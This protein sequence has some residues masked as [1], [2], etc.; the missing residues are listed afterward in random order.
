RFIRSSRRADDLPGRLSSHD[1]P[2]GPEALG[3]V[4]PEIEET[5]VGLVCL[6]PRQT[7]RDTESGRAG[8]V[9]AG[10][11]TAVDGAED[12][13]A[14][15]DPGAAPTTPAVTMGRG[16]VAT[17]LLPEPTSQLQRCESRDRHPGRHEL[18][19]DAGVVARRSAIVER[20]QPEQARSA[21]GEGSHLGDQLR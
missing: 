9:E 12:L 1:P 11:L 4:D 2:R 14:R 17:D 8:A 21:S 13:T 16:S 15:N 6:E 5:E 7:L 18:F 3:D 20:R 10:D 19:R